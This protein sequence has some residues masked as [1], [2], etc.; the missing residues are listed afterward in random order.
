MGGLAPVLTEWKLKTGGDGARLH[1]EYTTR[2]GHPGKPPAFMRQHTLRKNL[3][4]ALKACDLPMRL[5]WYQTTR[6]T[7]ASP[8][9]TGATPMYRPR[10]MCISPRDGAGPGDAFSK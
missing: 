6:H 1:A 9:G 10:L 8:P 7:F 5:T 4:D 2:D 3:R